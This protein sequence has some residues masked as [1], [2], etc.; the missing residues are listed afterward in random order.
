MAKRGIK[1]SI[2]FDNEAEGR[3]LENMRARR[4]PLHGT[5]ELT[6][7]CNLDCPYC[8][9]A[10][11]HGISPEKELSTGQ[12]FSLLDQVA[13]AGCLFLTFTG[14]EPLLRKDF[15]SI[16]AYTLKKGILPTIFTS[17][18]L[19]DRKMAAFFKKHPPYYLDITLHG[20]TARTYERVTRIKGSF[21]K[22]MAALR[23]LEKNKLPF[24][25][26]SVISTLNREEIGEIGKFVRGLG[27]LYRFDTMITPRLNGSLAPLPYR[28]SP[29]VIVGLNREDKRKW[30]DFLDFACSHRGKV[31]SDLLYK[32]RGG[33][34]SFYISSTGKL[35]LCLLDTNCQYDL[36]KGS[37]KKGWEAFIPGIRAKKATR[38]NKCSD[39]EVLAICGSCPAWSK[40]ETGSP[41]NPV[42]FR[43]QVARLHVNLLS[44]EAKWENAARGQEKNIV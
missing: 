12:V 13:E 4:L 6:R 27:R 16:H 18:T 28:L 38:R 7:R 43:C 41:E 30:E 20:V 9:V 15:A 11:D 32:C 2:P 33:L 8:Y 37:F 39:C 17:G 29:E 1:V 21:K 36:L 31:D 34:N 3:F 25:L 42:E 40:L 10:F 26:K 23:L 24:R 5:F 19:I 22:A 35:G 14:G 44:K